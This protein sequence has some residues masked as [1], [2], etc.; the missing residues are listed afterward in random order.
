MEAIVHA[1]EATQAAK[2][3]RHTHLI[4]VRN[5]RW[6]VWTG[7]LMLV[8]MFVGLIPFA[9]F[10][11]P[12]R[13]HDTALQVA[14]IYQSNTTGIR[15]GMLFV[16]TGTSLLVVFSTAISMQ[17][18]R[19][20][21]RAAP[22]LSLCQLA[23]AAIGTLVLCTGDIVLL[24]AAFDP[25]RPPE[26]TRAL[27]ELGWILLVFPFAPFC[28]QYLCVGAA[29]LQ[30]R[31]A[32]PVFPRWVAYYNFWVAVSFIP[33]G[34]IGFFH[35]GPF[36]WHGLISFYVAFATF[37][38]WFWVMFWSLRRALDRDVTPETAALGTNDG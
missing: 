9:H 29:I 22:V 34:I 20:E 23:A 38:G 26:I 31:R 37:G 6:M 1:R 17:M 5:Q 21:F 30:D 2:P 36:A 16:Y 35:R 25:G 24:A 18:L 3:Q 8:L 4:S 7:P 15:A 14:H 10:I 27:N 13:A 11:P 32:D 19:I 28:I 12:P 33:T